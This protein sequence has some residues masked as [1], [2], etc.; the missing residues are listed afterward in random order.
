[1]PILSKN[2]IQIMLLIAALCVLTA[3]TTN[4]ATGRSQFNAISP[5]QE[6]ALGNKA[7]PEFLQEFGGP[8]PSQHIQTYVSDLGHKLAAVSENPE[9]EWE[10]KVANSE[11]INAFALPG[12]K[13]FVTRGLLSKLDNEAQLAGILGHEVGHV[14][15]RHINDRILQSQIVT[16][17]GIGIAIAGE[18]AD[19]DWLKALGI[20]T[21]VGGGVALLAFSR[22]HEL[23]SD[24]LGLRYMTKLGYNPEAQVQ[25]MEI[26]KREEAG[27]GSIEFLSTHPVPETRIKELQAYIQ[28]KYPDYNQT[29]RYRFDAESYKTN[30][31]DELAKLP[32]IKK[33]Q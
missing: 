17:L 28:K 2:V 31:L 32:P 24:R 18:A 11:V 7:A 6:Q 1:M 5:E 30:V 16:G 23:E 22:N 27:G 9:L 21:S 3:C 33:K 12:G 10:F 15:A 14:T 25:V 13:V 4:K 20:G 19:E 29:G 8:I 26:F